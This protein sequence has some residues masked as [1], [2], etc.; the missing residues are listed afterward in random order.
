MKTVPKGWIV[1]QRRVDGTASFYRNWEDYKAGFGDLNGNF[2]FGLEKLHQ[3]AGPG[4]RASLRIDLKHMSK[5]NEMRHSEYSLFEISSESDG[6]KLTIDGYSGNAGN[7]LAVHNGMKFTTR[8]RD[9]DLYSGENC[10]VKCPSG[11]WYNSCHYVN[12]NGIYPPNISSSDP[13][14]LSWRGM[15]RSYGGIIFCEMKIRI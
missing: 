3:L 12:L 10:A 1:F 8:D 4:K 5:P 9:L 7:S 6:Y 11:F 13:K 2:W 15:T 14:Y